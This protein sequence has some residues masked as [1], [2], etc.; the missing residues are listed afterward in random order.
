MIP[1]EVSYLR[2]IFGNSGQGSRLAKL[3]SKFREMLSYLSVHFFMDRSD[4][5]A[6]C[7]VRRD[8][9]PV[10]KTVMWNYLRAPMKDNG[11]FDKNFISI[12]TSIKRGNK[13]SISKIIRNLYLSYYAGEVEINDQEPLADSR[14]AGSDEHRVQEISCTPGESAGPFFFFRST[15]DV[16]P[17]LQ[18]VS[19]F[20][21]PELYEPMIHQNG[22]NVGNILKQIQNMKGKIRMNQLSRWLY[23][24][25]H[26]HYDRISPP[27]YVHFY[28]S[29]LPCTRSGTGIRAGPF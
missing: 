4:E 13:L 8:V 25:F 10:G 3:P 14:Q 29:S 16:G 9:I 27:G 1:V 28:N 6:L 12:N 17:A 2:T 26:P 19:D 21:V 11:S 5:I 20:G 7:P 18:S 22:L 15:P 24:L 23:F